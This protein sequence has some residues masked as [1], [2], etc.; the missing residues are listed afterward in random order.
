MIVIIGAGLSG[1]LTGYRLKEAKIPFK[2]LEAKDRIGGRIFTKM[3]TKETPLE[4]GATWFGKQH[5]SLI[6]LLAELELNAFPQYT[7]NF[8]FFD[9]PKSP[10]HGKHKLPQQEANYRIAGGSKSI[11]EAL[12]NSLGTQDIMLNTKVT[13]IKES[14]NKLVVSTENDN[15]FKA[16]QV[17]LS[18]P[19]KIW[20]HQIRFSPS[21]P[22]Q[23]E[24]SAKNTQTWMEDS[25][26]AALEFKKAFWRD[27][28][29]PAT[30]MSNFG[31]FVE[32]YDHTNQQ[33]NKF[34]LCGFLNP[35]FKH[36]NIKKREQ[37][38]FK[39]LSTI[40]GEEVQ[41]A[42]GYHEYIWSDDEFV[43]WPKNIFMQ[44]HQNNGNQ[45][46]RES[47]YDNRLII[48]GSESAANFPGYM[49]GAVA[50]GENAFTQILKTFEK[51]SNQQNN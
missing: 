11:I 20:A 10:H 44:P 43:K 41:Q 51:D 26:K 1:L 29:Q 38:V 16:D 12:G 37:E 13:D 28:E 47:L 31:P 5:Q 2:I 23:M 24:E 34:A 15:V 33:E 39:Q 49:D 27:H 40:L 25:I 36:L 9:D 48:S 30:I 21:L 46:F 18:V 42:I 22:K 7:G 6:K 32:C 17:V 35:E 45:I 4:M 19:P 3:T 50:A 8:F 14:E